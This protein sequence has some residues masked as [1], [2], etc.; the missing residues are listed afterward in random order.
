MFFDRYCKGIRNG[1]ES[2]PRVRIEV[3]D[4]FDI[5]AKGL[6]ERCAIARTTFY[7]FFKD[8]YDL[9]GRLEQYL[10]AELEL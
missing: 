5:T 6:S 2:T 4:H 10:L 8:T 1:W 3:Q 9:L 7:R